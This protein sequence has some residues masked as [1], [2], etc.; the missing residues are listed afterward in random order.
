M[1]AWHE[2]LALADA[3]LHGMAQPWLVCVVLVLTTFLLEDLAIAAGAALAAQGTLSWELAFAAV[4]IGIALGDLGL[5][6][7]G[8]AAQRLAYL[9]RRLDQSRAVWVRDQLQARLSGAVL[10]ARVV[11]GLR[12]VTYTACGLFGLPFWPFC[13][14]VLLAVVLWTAGLLG[15]AALFGAALAALL[16]IPAPVAVALPIVVLALVLSAL[17]RNKRLGPQ[18]LA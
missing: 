9:R 4:A 15:L 18:G 12:F 14:W 8:L 16:G 3:A 13:A 5:Y 10:L 2:W 6:G 7:L 1:L 17:R 11:P